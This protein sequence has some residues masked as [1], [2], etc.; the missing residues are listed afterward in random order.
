MG[1]S[2]LFCLRTGAI[3]IGA[4]SA[5][6]PSCPMS[7]TPLLPSYQQPANFT[8]EPLPWAQDSLKGFSSEQIDFHYNKHHKGYAVKLSKAAEVNPDIKKLSIEDIIRQRTP[9]FNL[10]AQIWNHTFYWQCLCPNGGG[11][12]TGP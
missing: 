8:V 10:A 5:A 6:L 1:D 7:R 4:V 9:Q 3:I 2:F 11:E 12:P